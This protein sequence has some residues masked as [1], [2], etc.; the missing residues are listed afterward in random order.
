MESEYI[1]KLKELEQ[2]IED[3][4]SSDE[5]YEIT[6]ELMCMAAPKKSPLVQ[7]IQDLCD[8]YPN[9]AD[10]GRAVRNRMR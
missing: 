4:R 10:L 5:L 2:R 7:D 8:K 3:G 9:D 6:N 1:K